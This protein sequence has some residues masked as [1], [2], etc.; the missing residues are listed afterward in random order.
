MDTTS[1]WHKTVPLPRFPALDREI[2]VDV[3]VVGAGLTGITAA[4]LLKQEGLTVALVER[5]RCAGVDTGHT[6]AHLTAVTD[7]RLH[8]LARRFGPTVA[9][10]VWDAGT[11]AIDRVAS[12]VQ[13]EDIDCGFKRLPGYLHAATP[14]E[15]ITEFQR[16]IE[17]AHE[18]GISA[19]FQSAIPLF[20]VP[21]IIFPRQAIFHPL[22]Y[23]GR[24]LRT[25][26]GD[27]SHVFEETDA[28]EIEKEPRRLRTKG[29]QIHFNHLIL[30]THNPLVG[31]A[32]LIRAT[33]FQ[34]KLSLY[35]S[36]AI[37][38]RLPRAEYPEASFWDTSDPYN[39]LRIEEAGDHMYAIYG[40]EDHKTG[41]TADTVL[42]YDRLEGRLRRFAP[43]AKVNARWSGQVI[44]TNDG[45]PFIGEIADRQFIATGFSGNGLTFGTLAAMMAT[46]QIMGR[47]N[48]W[49]EL[50]DPHRTKLRGGTWTYL[51]E[52][53][54]F[55]LRLVRDRLAA[56]E[57]DSLRDLAPGEG[58]I[59]QL[60]KRKVAAYRDSRGRVTMCSAICTHLQCVVGW[61]TA[62]KTWDCPCHGS[63]FHPDGRVIS[64]PAEEPLVR[65]SPSTGR[66]LRPR[67]ATASGGS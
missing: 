25:I 39:Y 31:V 12:L 20:L 30:A 45:L 6:T 24:L 46:D 9:R 48:A 66:P 38:A 57:G 42:P 13:A 65:L 32:N 53:K 41:Q 34:T 23:L 37:G 33:L 21:G 49:R 17:A 3:V 15:D 61:N 5:E 64:G 56:P 22:A 11:T 43:Q 36:Y 35:T 18:L 59:V 50:F 62:E 2:T 26:P 8:Q 54:D 19:E 16:D 27:G 67:R 63:R 51:K 1:H 60:K 55:P 58:K 7:V 29:G 14:G 52:N 40:G 47:A 10:A 4:Y 44:E 28:H